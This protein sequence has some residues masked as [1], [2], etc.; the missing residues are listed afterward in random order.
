MAKLMGL[1]KI[2]RADGTRIPLKA[3]LYDTSIS[4]VAAALSR[5]FIVCDRFRFTVARID[6]DSL[7]AKDFSQDLKIKTGPKSKVQRPMSVVPSKLKRMVD[8]EFDRSAKQTLGIGHRHW[9]LYLDFGHW[10]IDLNIEVLIPWRILCHLH[11]ASTLDLTRSSE[12]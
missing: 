5:F 2:P 7:Q 6:V 11:F 8:L 1:I 4:L 3:W 9:T 10:T 12:R